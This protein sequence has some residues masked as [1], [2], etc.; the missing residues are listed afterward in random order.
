MVG[1]TGT[2]EEEDADE[3]LPV[4]DAVFELLVLD[5]TELELEMVIEAST[6][7]QYA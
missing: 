2:E 6:P 4:L 3:P 5:I 7:T 1:L